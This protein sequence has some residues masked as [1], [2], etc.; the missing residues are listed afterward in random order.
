MNATRPLIIHNQ[1]LLDDSTVIITVSNPKKDN[2]VGIRE[3]DGR[4]IIAGRTKRDELEYS[5]GANDKSLTSG[6]SNGELL[7]LCAGEIS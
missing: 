5:A 6:T 4:I 1:K 7:S 2:H 3:R